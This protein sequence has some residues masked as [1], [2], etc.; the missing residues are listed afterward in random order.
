MQ[1]L[2]TLTVRQHLQQDGISY[3]KDAAISVA[4]RYSTSMPICLA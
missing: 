1:E 3:D 2:A 4:A